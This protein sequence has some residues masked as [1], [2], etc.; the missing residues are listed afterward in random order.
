M[1]FFC[2]LGLLMRVVSRIDVYGLAD[3]IYLFNYCQFL[4][5]NHPN[6]LL[7]VRPK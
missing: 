3:T 6:L 2:G 5:N 4:K 7:A 1:S